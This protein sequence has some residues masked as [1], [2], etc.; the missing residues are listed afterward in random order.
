MMIAMDFPNAVTNAS[1]FYNRRVE[2]EKAVRALLSGKCLPV[3]I[4]GER[5]VGKTSLQNVVMEA[6]SKAHPGCRTLVVDPRVCDS[7]DTFA[8]T[9][10]RRFT[11]YLK[12]D[13]RDTGLVDAAGRFHLD[14]PDQ[15]DAAVSR[16]LPAGSSEQFVLCVDEFDEI[17]RLVGKAGEAEKDRLFGLVHHLMERTALPLRLFFTM[18]RVPDPARDE[19]PAWL[20]T[21]SEI[22]ELLPLDT[23]AALGMIDWLMAGQPAV[24]DAQ[25]KAMIA[26]L[27]GGHPYFVKLLLVNLSAPFMDTEARRIGAAEVVN[28]AL[29]RA[30]EDARARYAIENVYK[31]HF[32]PAEKSVMLYLAE[33]GEP[34]DGEE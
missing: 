3:M 13:I 19:Y 11:T 29:P 1:N 24:L 15:F 9:V 28:E 23:S 12:C 18:T 5:R 17:V 26:D 34:V 2:L 8:E 6:L 4:I 27:S 22:I 20:I 10:M 21:K 16:I 7:V 33:R 30:L 31:A 25:A 32:T 14:T